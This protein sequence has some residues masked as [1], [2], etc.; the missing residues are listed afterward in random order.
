MIMKKLMLAGLGA[1]ALGL[2]MVQAPATAEAGTR[3][4]VK[5]DG[6]YKSCHWMKKKAKFF[7]HIGKHRKAAYWWDRYFDCLSWQQYTY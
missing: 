1:A 3:V 5:Y 6:V 2:T 7:E 4:F